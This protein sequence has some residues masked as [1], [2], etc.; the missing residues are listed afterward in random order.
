MFVLLFFLQHTFPISQSKTVYY[1]IF[2]FLVF[3]K[4]TYPSYI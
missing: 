1:K 2:Y 3:Q 4:Y